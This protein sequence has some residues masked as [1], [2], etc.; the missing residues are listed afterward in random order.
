[1][2]RRAGGPVPPPLPP[3]RRTVGQLVAETLR[4]YGQRFWA[5]LALGVGPALLAV[6]AAELDD[7]AR[8]IA[9]A[10]AGPLVL[11]ATLVQAVR[12]A[13][14]NLHPQLVAAYTLGVAAFVPLAI[15]RLWTFP[16]IYLVALA[17]YAVVALGVPAALVEGRGLPG[18]LRR[19]LT[20]ARADFVH[21]LGGL[22]TF[23]IVI[24]LSMFVLFSTL[25]TVG[26]QGSLGATSLAFL[27]LTPLF[28]LGTALLYVD[29]AAR[30]GSR[31]R[32]R[33]G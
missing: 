7:V 31:S 13:H 18:A 29:Q 28:F 8:W 26:D 30:V 16:G 15:S 21:A 3:E 12:L 25:R 27:L 2:S 5:S 32:E 1:V 22:A 19:A 17:W 33:G 6:A 11:G 4:L 14:R 10:G 20:L 24:V 9:V 23:V